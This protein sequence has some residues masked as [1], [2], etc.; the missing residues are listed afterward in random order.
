MT[1]EATTTQK[2]KRVFLK[3]VTSTAIITTI[4]SRSVW[5]MNHVSNG[6]IMP[7]MNGSDFGGVNQIILQDPQYWIGNQVLMS[8]SVL[9][10]PFDDLFGGY[11]FKNTQSHHNHQTTISDILNG[12][13]NKPDF[14][15]GPDEIN[16]WMVSLYFNALYSE[17]YTFGCYYPVV[18][19]GKSF[20][21][22]QD[23]AYYLYTSARNDTYSMA[24][25]IRDI[26][27]LG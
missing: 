2:S 27:E 15:Y 17:N 10:Q 22:A 25:N 20:V 6:S 19:H 1:E 23:L 16:L 24:K 13:K 7:S 26:H 18:G 4:P 9:D 12:K 8:R 21:T 11:A 3:K 5:G 14:Y